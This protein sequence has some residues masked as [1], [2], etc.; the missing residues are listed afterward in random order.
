MQDF[1]K[2]GVFYLGREFDP[3][4]GQ[5]TDGLLL[6][7]SRDLTTHAVCVGM[8]G[9]GKTGLCISLLE[10]AAMDGIPAIAIDPKGDLSNLMLTFPGLSPE[11]FLP[12]IDPEEAERKG[13]SL[14][15]FA[16]QTADAWKN[17]LAQWGQDGARIS[18]LRKRAEFRLFTPG[19]SS[20]MPLSVL[21]SLDAPPPGVMNEPEALA[22]RIETAVSSFLTLAGETSIEVHGREHVLL[23]SILG[24][25]WGEGRDM[26]L[27]ELVKAVQSPPMK[28]LGVLELESFYPSS[29][30]LKLAMKLNSLVA[31]PGFAPWT[32]GE[33]L[34]IGSLLRSPEGK[35]RISILSIAHLSDEQRMFFVSLLLNEVVAWM[36]SLPGTGSLRAILYMD[37]IFGFF[38]PGAAPP[39]KKPMLT[40]LKQA[41]AFGLGVVLAAQNPVDL[42]YRGLAN[43]G[44]WFVGRLQTERDK[45]RLMD[46]LESA[47]ASIMER[48][49]LDRLL[50]GLDKRVFLLH[51]VHRKNPVLFQ[52][53]WAMSYLRGPLAGAQMKALDQRVAGPVPVPVPV[54]VAS[55]QQKEVSSSQPWTPSAIETYHAPLES[56][57][58]A[59][60]KVVYRPC[61]FASAKL[62]F[63]SAK[64][65]VDI[66][67]DCTIT[68][69]ITGE[70]RDDWSTATCTRG[71]SAPMNG[72]PGQSAEY[73]AFAPEAVSAASLKH[74][75]SRASTWL[76]QEQALSIWA[77]DKPR[78][79][80]E[81]GE[82][83]GAFA[84]RLI[85]LERENRDARVEKIRET[86]EK[87]LLAIQ[88]KVRKAEQKVER[89]KGQYNHQKTQT[90]VSVGATIM[91]ALLGRRI[92][93]GS[94]GRA[95]T[96]VRGATR[97]SRE[98]QDIA[99]AEDD[100]KVQEERLRELE[101][102]FRNTLDEMEAPLRA[103][104][105]VLEQKLVR[106]RKADTH[107]S[108]TG[109]LWMPWL[110]GD[111]GTMEPG[112][113]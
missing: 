63:V 24:H 17:G 66:W 62:H 31:S 84:A 7:D 103:E 18:E 88:D 40:L 68:L 95:T 60:Q 47:S 113:R 98:R 69:P 5:A 79:V 104:E 20:G 110:S 36:R 34:N 64:D 73:E 21:H 46:G 93:T 82:D 94:V 109:I 108:R 61:L 72:A 54:P 56:A 87:R 76:Y 48:S 9:S 13:M 35:P 37:E 33:P 12:W 89:E 8:T 19:G 3:E 67:E 86:F 44:T 11:E 57:P 6:Y 90:A 97:A 38:P 50:S 4:S 101:E 100:L 74:F 10:E 32:R 14:S 41:R 58:S 55:A 27:E 111:S 96:A 29:E 45:L 49:E 71:R 81:P 16:A 107:I 22:E 92:G 77:C 78:A 105:L 51:D 53:R 15:D 52:T 25:A 106:P 26:S 80:S 28:Q 65:K 59:G 85:Q 43:T 99:A 83:K 112:R 1:E 2:M 70:H 39:S 75:T 102:E 30:R 42:D 23:S 91:G